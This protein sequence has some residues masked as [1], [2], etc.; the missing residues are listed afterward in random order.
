MRPW[1]YLIRQV[2]EVTAFSLTSGSVLI[3]GESGTGKELIARLI[4]DLDPRLASAISS[5]S[6]ARRSCPGCRGA[7]SSATNAVPSPA[8]SARDGAFALADGGTLF[9]DEVGELPLTLQAE[10]LRVVQEGKYKRV[11]S[12]PW[13]Q[14]SFRLVCA[15]NRDL[16]AGRR[17]QLP[18]DLYYRIA[19]WVCRTAAAAR[20]QGRHPAADPPLPAA[21]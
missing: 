21:S 4:H 14:T 13:Q 6:T 5:C 1:R 3:V 17:G 18:A 20:A 7:S 12:N 16:E 2:V 11:G 10:L 8:R 19:G 9:L 15:T